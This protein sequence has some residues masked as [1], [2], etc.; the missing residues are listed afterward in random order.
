[1]N[2]DVT[3]I[4]AFVAGLLSFTSPCVLPLIPIYLAHL[5][6]VGIGEGG[7]AARSRVMANA[8]AFV[9]GFSAVFVLLGASIGAAGGL[10]SESRVWVVRIG[11][12]LLVVMGLHLVGLIRIPWLDRE[13]RMEIAPRASG[14]GRVA[15]SLAVGAAFGAGWTPCVGPILGAIL[16]MAAGES[17][18]GNAAIL[19]AV[20]AAGFAIPFLAAALSFGT[21]PKI[22]RALT[23]R[24]AVLNSLSGALILALGAVLLLGVYEELF[25]DLARLAPWR[26]WEP[27]I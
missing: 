13:Y 10:V 5:A 19:L 1:M 24:L 9:V 12:A 23:R 20:Y 7:L 2:P 21:A 14:A 6:G 15:S 22:V 27:E 18:A 3:H 11:G 4:A 16:T 26:P 8:V 25:A 17:S